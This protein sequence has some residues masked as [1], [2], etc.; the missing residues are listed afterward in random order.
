LHYLNNRQNA[1]WVG[2]FYANQYFNKS[3]RKKVNIY[4]PEEQLKAI[5]TV[6]KS[7]MSKILCNFFT[8]ANLKIICEGPD[9]VDFSFN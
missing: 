3:R 7:K 5:K 4:G 2:N 6:S 9:K 1:A 8:K